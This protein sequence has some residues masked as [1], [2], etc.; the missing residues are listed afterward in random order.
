MFDLHQ[1]SRRLIQRGTDYNGGDLEKNSPKDVQACKE[2]TRAG[3]T[4]VPACLKERPMPNV[5]ACLKSCEKHAVY[6]I[7]RYVGCETDIPDVFS[8][9]RENS[10]EDVSG[11]RMIGRVFST[12]SRKNVKKN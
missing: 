11:T 4:N 3:L 9:S 6:F 5:Q 1:R 10:L 2:Q 8:S 7:C 12:F